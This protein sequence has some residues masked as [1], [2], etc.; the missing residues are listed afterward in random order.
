MSN[1][2]KRVEKAKGLVFSHNHYEPE[3]YGTWGSKGGDGYGEKYYHV[4]LRH[5]RETVATPDG[6]KTIS[7]F[8][9]DC[10]KN[11][12]KHTLCACPGNEKTVCYHGLGAIYQSFAQA[13]VKKLVSFFETYESA[14]RMAFGGKIAKVK[15]AN[16]NGVVWCVVKD[17]PARILSVQENINL[18]RGPADDEGID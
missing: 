8:T 13:K 14:S 3:R 10:Q 1:L 16:G 5:G 6:Q 17:W 9:V 18:M 2:S 4:T 11:T 7:V 12:G 15:S